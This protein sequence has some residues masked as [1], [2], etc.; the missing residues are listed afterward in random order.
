MASP[1]ILSPEPS[2]RLTPRLTPRADD[3]DP[4][5]AALVTPTPPPAPDDAAD[6]APPPEPSPRPTPRLTPRADDPDPAALVTPTPPPAPDDAAAAA[7]AAPPPPPPLVVTPE[8][9]PPPPPNSATL[10]RQKS[11]YLTNQQVL[12]S[13]AGNASATMISRLFKLYFPDYFSKEPEWCDY[14]YDIPMCS[15][16][17]FDCLLE[18]KNKNMCELY[19]AADAYVNKTFYSTNLLGPDITTKTKALPND[20]NPENLSALLYYFI[21]NIIAQRVNFERDGIDPYDAITSFFEY[22]KTKTINSKKIKEILHYKEVDKDGNQKY[23]QDDKTY[24]NDKINTLE[25]MLKDVKKK[26]TTSS[27][28]IHLF[29]AH[30]D[31]STKSNPTRRYNYKAGKKLTYIK[32]SQFNDEDIKNLINFIVQVLTNGLYVL[33]SFVK[34]KKRTFYDMLTKE[35]E[36]GHAIIINE[37]TQKNGKTLLTIK[38]SWGR[39]GDYYSGDKYL[40]QPGLKNKIDLEAILRQI[41]QQYRIYALVPSDVDLKIKNA[42]A[43]R[44]AKAK[45]AA[46]K[47][48][49]EKA[50][51]DK[52]AADKVA[53]D[54]AAAKREAKAKAAAEKVAADKAAADKAA[55]KREAKA[56]EDKDDDEDEEG[57]DEDEEDEAKEAKEAKEDKDDD[58][59]EKGEDEDEDEDKE[60]KEAKEDKDDDEDEKGEDEDED[61]DDAKE[62]WARWSALDKEKK[63]EKAREAVAAT[64]VTQ[65]ESDFDMISHIIVNLFKVSFSEYFTEST[66]DDICY[67]YYNT[68]K[69]ALG[70]VFECIK[71]EDFKKECILSLLLF[72]FIY[73][74]LKETTGVHYK[75]IAYFFKFLKTQNIDIELVQA[76][77]KYNP[78]VSTL[79]EDEKKNVLE[80]ISHLTELL[81]NV[82]G[83][84]AN[85]SFFPCLYYGKFSNAKVVG[86]E[87]IYKYPEIEYTSLVENFSRKTNF[88]RIKDIF[89][90]KSYEKKRPLRPD[91]PERPKREDK[92]EADRIDRPERPDRPP[93][94]DKQIFQ[95]FIIR[96]LKKKLYVV[97]ITPDK[98]K[99]ITGISKENEKELNIKTKDDTEKIMIDNLFE[100][101]TTHDVFFFSTYDEEKALGGG[102]RKKYKRQTKKLKI[103][104]KKKSRVSKRYK[105][106]KTKSRTRKLNKKYQAK[107]RSLSKKYQAKSRTLNKKYQAKSRTLNKKYQAK[108]RL[109]KKRK[110][111]LNIT[112]K[113]I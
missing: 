16:K 2:P 113:I 87:I 58:E 50:A 112:H 11:E 17:I 44:E 41:E 57:E 23:T 8:P 56:K 30:Q 91:R 79:T 4:D 84:L 60:A 90:N 55:A 27:F 5:P 52:A 99:I 71:Q 18:D 25:T 111:L 34:Y 93:R 104:N 100:D 54:K 105:T 6:A 31:Y 88:K 42:Q 110:K 53:A 7:D 81:M 62:D 83:K 14:Y 45:A 43:E 67:D 102:N 69:C 61:K 20:W 46:E 13:C 3:P 95:Q 86:P 72:H 74:I 22:F 15:K 85:G 26:L 10:K 66:E 103:K 92:S 109:S 21:F 36:A 33:M 51:A 38:N 28:D 108:S 12:F 107:S 65:Q 24:F 39:Y 32:P 48:A 89:A 82:K 9:P 64:K 59:D 73:T 68:S 63:L 1:V 77:F 35:E 70:N 97:L 75:K 106:Y 94:P 29:Y 37:V 19:I 40:N 96:I 80:D 49:A 98:T 47:A 76:K 78:N 101:T